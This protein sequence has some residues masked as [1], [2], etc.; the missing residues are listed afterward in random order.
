MSVC[1]AFLPSIK[2]TVALNGAVWGVHP[3]KVTSEQSPEVTVEASPG[4]SGDKQL[5]TGNS[6]AVMWE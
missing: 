2:L 4:V 5:E 3:G 1:P 6:K